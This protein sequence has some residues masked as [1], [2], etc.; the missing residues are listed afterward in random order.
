MQNLS[1]LK[2][3][4]DAFS[5]IKRFKTKLNQTDYSKSLNL[6]NSGKFEL[7]MK[8]ICEN[9]DKIKKVLSNF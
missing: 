4:R 5:I 8:N 6:P 3:K 9:E 7:S 2:F 1:Y